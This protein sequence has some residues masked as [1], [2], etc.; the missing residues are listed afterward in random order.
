MRKLHAR[1][2]NTDAALRDKVKSLISLRQEIDRRILKI[3]EDSGSPQELAELRKA[4][5]DLEETLGKVRFEGL[6]PDFAREAQ[7]R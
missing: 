5:H 3:E 2:I 6:T 4:R 7:P 1:L